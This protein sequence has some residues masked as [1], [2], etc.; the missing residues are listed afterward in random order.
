MTIELNP[1]TSGYSTGLINDNFQA[2]EDYVNDKL[3]QRDGVEVG[4][5]NQMEVDLDMNSH[6][7]Y[8]LP[9]PVLEHQAAR[10]QDVQNAVA[11][12][13][14][15]LITFTP[16]GSIT[17]E[18]VQGAIQELE[19]QKTEGFSTVSEMESSDTSAL[20]DGDVVYTLGVPFEFDGT[21]FA[22]L[23]RVSLRAFGAVGDGVTDDS[24]AYADAL[25]KGWPVS[26]NPEDTYLINSTSQIENKSIDFDGRGCSFFL[27]DTE[28][29]NVKASFSNVVNITSFTD[30]TADLSDGTTGVGEVTV[31]TVDDATGYSS[32]D[33]V[34]ILSDD[35][36]L[37]ETSDRRRAEYAQVFSVTGSDITLFTRIV[38]VYSTSPRLAKANKD[39]SLK[40][41][42]FEATPSSSAVATWSTPA[43][44]IIGYV[45]PEIGHGSFFDL[46]ERAV[47]LHSCYRPKTWFLRGERIR[48]SQ[49]NDAFGYLIHEVSCYAGYHHRPEGRDVRHVY[50]CSAFGTSTL[51][52]SIESYG[53][54]RNSVVDHGYGVNCKASAFDTHADG[55]NITFAVCVAESPYKGNLGALFNYG[56]RGRNNKCVGCFSIGGNGYRAFSDFGHVDNSRNHEFIGCSHVFNRNEEEPRSAF[57]VFGT[58][59]GPVSSVSIK[60]P[61]V[62]MREGNFASIRAE[63]GDVSVYNPTLTVRQTSV[64]DTFQAVAGGVIRSFGGM[65]D[66]SGSTGANLRTIH[67]YNNDSEVYVDGLRIVANSSWGI[68]ADLDGADGTAV[69]TNID[70]SQAPSFNATGVTG[71]SGA[72][73]VYVD[74]VIDGGRGGALANMSSVT[75]SSS[76]GF[77]IQIGVRGSPVVYYSVIAETAGVIGSSFDEGHFYNQELVVRNHPTSTDSVD[78]QS[79]TNGS[80]GADETIGVG[81][82]Y[83]LRWDGFNWVSA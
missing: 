8:N 68:L 51:D 21:G 28:L 17:S 64:G 72:P 12:G 57:E 36:I 30:T 78:I 79:G 26:G 23:T 43:M 65:V 7:V 61:K 29:L 39:V 55:E 37:G 67:C 14:A 2:I 31:L 22:P 9:E 52:S 74:W 11:G 18:N 40:F 44:R 58:S 48:T 32:G 69:A 80:F 6:F 49:A 33:I 24:S 3:L 62:F 66:Y 63:W 46:L 15:N 45:S 71:D 34:K 56:L 4:E 77:P 1:I 82:S 19:D 59:S 25:S 35:L 54:T 83:R 81:K 73:T 75:R 41:I 50:S 16:Y 27:G 10:L 42:N 13:A 5:V 76:G 20:S 70:T 38:G 47:L 60:D 53:G